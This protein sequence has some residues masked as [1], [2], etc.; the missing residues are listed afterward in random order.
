VA[1]HISN[2]YLDLSQVV[3]G[4]ADEFGLHARR[5][6]SPGEAEGGQ[7][8]ADWMLL[9]KDPAAL[10]A[11]AESAATEAPPRR[12]LWTDDHS[13]LFGILR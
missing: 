4:L 5:V 8:P 1:V 11:I 7:F 2:R 12:V 3:A 6:V 9:S 10:A 13:D